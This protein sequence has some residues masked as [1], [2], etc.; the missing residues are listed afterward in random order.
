MAS[1]GRAAE[2]TIKLAI[3]IDADN[4]QPSMSGLLL[5]EVAKYG[6]ACVKRAYGD[7][8]G[9]SLTGW[10][11]Q[12]LKQAIQPIQQFTYTHGKNATDMAMIIDAMDLLYSNR[13]DGFCLVSS[14]SDFTRLAVRIRE[15]GLPVYGFGNRTTPGPFVAACNRFVYVENLTTKDEHGTQAAEIASP[16]KLAAAAV[17]NAQLVNQLESAIEVASEEDGWAPLADVGSLIT[18]RHPDFDPRSYGYSKLSGLV[19]ATSIFEVTRRSR[20]DGKSQIVYVRSKHRADE[21]L[22]K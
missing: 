4:A 10:K 16:Q 8:A 22:S 2:N 1:D 21:H 3:L 12:L 7:W 11:V 5:A 19:A 15:S 6:T 14:D 13:F 18:K 17:N 20:G 9:T